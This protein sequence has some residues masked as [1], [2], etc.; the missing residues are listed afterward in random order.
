MQSADDETAMPLPGVS[1]TEPAS[2]GASTAVTGDRRKAFA[3]P[4]GR[5]LDPLVGTLIGDRYVVDRVLGEGGMGRVYLA[6]HKVIERRVAIKV[7]HPELAKDREAVSRFVRE[8]KSASSIGNPHIV[9]ILDFGELPDGTTYFVMEHLEGQP[10]SSL[11]EEQGALPPVAVCEIALQICDGLA[12]AHD[13]EIVHRDLKPDNVVL[14][15][16]GNGYFVKILDFGIAKVAGKDGSTKLTMAGAV[17]GTPHYMSP[18]QAAGGTLDQR[19]DIYS[20]G[21]MLYEMTSGEMP[22]NADNFM[23]ILTQHLYKPPPLF[24]TLPNVPN[25]PP[26]LEAVILKCLA[27]KAALRYASMR[28]LADEIRLVMQGH[29]PLAVQSLIDDE[30]S[31]PGDYFVRDL[32][33]ERPALGSAGTPRGPG[34]T[35]GS[36]FTTG[37]GAA[38]GSDR[39]MSPTHMT[40]PELAR[41]Q[42]GDFDHD[43][44]APPKKKGLAPAVVVVFTAIFAVGGAGAWLLRP[45]PPDVRESTGTGPGPT[46]PPTGSPLP[47]AAPSDATVTTPASS[48]T[49]PVADAAPVMV[50]VSGEPASATVMIGTTREKLP[51]SVRVPKGSRVKVTVEGGAAYL[52]KE[53]EL[54]GSSLEVKVTLTKAAVPGGQQRAR[55]PAVPAEVPNDYAM[56]ND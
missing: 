1:E 9:D 28:D 18:E 17:F 41:G 26:G 3:S 38:V 52:S 10:L 27:K 40:N 16:Q 48:A 6:H 30:P 12:A 7:L 56:P 20:L 32:T 55:P 47:H 54:D 14:R 37:S 23:G 21:V 36:G 46:M 33:F 11:L 42:T 29:E 15:P 25:C 19:S 13:K 4:A 53:L 51:F 43:I 44:P 22:F 24:R 49:V 2:E 50:L 8:A 31:I 34:H 5:E 45:A 39:T 35:T